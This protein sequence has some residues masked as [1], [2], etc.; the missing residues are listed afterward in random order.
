MIR[1][2]PGHVLVGADADHLELRIITAVAQIKAYLDVFQDPNGD[3][4]AMTAS[5]MFGDSFKKLVRKSDQWTNL[6]KLGKGIAYASFYGSGDETVHSVVTSAEEDGKPVY[7][8]LTVREVALMRRKWLGN[9]PEMKR[10]WD[11]TVDEY[12]EQGYLVD[13]YWGRRRDFLDGE[14]FNE[15]INFGIQSC[16]AHI[17]HDA[18]FKLMDQI[19]FF[20]W[21]HGTGL[22]NQC[23]DALVFEVPMDHE[24]YKGPDAEFKWCPPGCNCTANNVARMIKEAMNLEIKQLPGVRFSATPEID[25]TWDKV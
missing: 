17:I 2:A 1:A 25:M 19:P 6:R 22:I 23:H 20:K 5:L 8:N 13:P 24:K 9:I 14:K 7:P 12:R 11:R 4:H 10:W 18:T 15:L 21:G 3:P 16:G